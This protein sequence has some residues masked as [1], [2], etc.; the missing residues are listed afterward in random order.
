[1]SVGC[2]CR[3]AANAVS[4]DSCHL[5]GWHGTGALSSKRAVTILDTKQT[6]TEC[7]GTSCTR[8]SSHLSSDM[9]WPRAMD[10]SVPC[11]LTTL[12]AFMET[13]W[14]DYRKRRL[15]EF[16]DHCS[17]A[18]NKHNISVSLDCVVLECCIK[19]H[20]WSCSLEFYLKKKKVL[21]EFWLKLLRQESRQFQKKSVCC[22][23]GLRVQTGTLSTESYRIKISIKSERRWSCHTKYSAKI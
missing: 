18:F 20:F 11:H 19:K 4:R 10:H 13:G 6:S 15:T 16:S 2:L 22:F 17:S 12:S 8:G 21:N 5:G 23:V 7:S 9:R 14:F 3:H 1:M